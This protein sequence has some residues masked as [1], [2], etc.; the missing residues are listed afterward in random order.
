MSAEPAPRV[1]FFARNGFEVLKSDH[2]GSV[3]TI[4]VRPWLEGTSRLGIQ[5]AALALADCLLS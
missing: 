3:R 4:A 2:Q 1:P 5:A